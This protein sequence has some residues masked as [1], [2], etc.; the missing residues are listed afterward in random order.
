MSWKSTICLSIVTAWLA[1]AA[2]AQQSA[3][4]AG[5]PEESVNPGVNDFWKG[6]DTQ[7]L[8]DVLESEEREIYLSRA[9]LADLI[10][11][12]AGAAVADIGAGSGFMAEELA[13]RVGTGGKVY[14]V[15]IN[16]HL[17]RQLAERAESEGLAQLETVVCSESSVDLPP[18]S[19]DLAFIC[20]TYHHFEYPE[21]TLRSLHRALKPGGEVIVVDFH[22]VAGFTR[23]RM[24]EH[25]RAGQA[26]FTA[27]ILGA[28]FELVEEIEAPFLSENYVLRF[29]KR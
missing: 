1:T 3:G 21:S 6:E 4:P 13:R 28:G 2:A 5:S 12:P 18:A 27:E 25:V 8:I 23:E 24:M 9:E 7:P 10:A 29:R 11:P 17:M 26:V 20:D 14:A 19:I 16:P 22:R 15:D